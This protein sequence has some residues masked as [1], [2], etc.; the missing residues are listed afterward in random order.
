MNCFI[1]KPL[2][3]LGFVL[4]MI[5]TCSVSLAD[6]QQKSS[7]SFQEKLQALETSAGG[8][9]GISAVDTTN[10]TELQYHADE[11]FALGCTAKVLGVGAILQKSINDKQLLNQ[12]VTYTKDDV[13]IHSPITEKH[14][15]E[16][17]TIS[18][19]CEAAIIV[20][21]NTAMNLLIKKLKPAEQGK[22]EDVTAF[23]RSIGDKDFNITQ[24][25]PKEA[26]TDPNSIDNTTTPA[27]MKKS[28]QDLAFG[29]IL[30]PSQQK[31]LLTWLKHNQTG[32]AR[33]RAGVPKG[34]IVGDKTGTGATYGATNDIGIIWPPKCQPLI[35]AV[36]FKQNEK[37][38][39]PQ[40]RVVASATRL[41]LEEFAKTNSCIH[42]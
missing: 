42:L 23:A 38:A 20:S 21:D 15:N 9:L 10:N 3:S 41:I 36:Y 1:F 22:P 13:V 8:R 17:M 12:H 39:A 33:I 5:A 7:A 29:Q 31:E 37:D 4:S 19:L 2:L 14:I 6:N 30:P 27:A 40:S 11:R 34:W 25:W 35:V 18:K 16:G 32:N 28:L 24:W 26:Y